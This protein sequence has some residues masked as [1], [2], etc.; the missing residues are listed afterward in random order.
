M[1]RVLQATTGVSIETV[2]Y[3]DQ[4]AY[5]VGMLTDRQIAPVL[6]PV[7]RDKKALNRVTS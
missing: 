2:H 7:S 1:I 3:R 4:A 6:Q 5:A